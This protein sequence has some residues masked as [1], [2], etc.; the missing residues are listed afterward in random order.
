MNPRTLHLHYRCPTEPG[1]SGGPVF[2][3][4]WTSSPS[5]P[6]E[7]SPMPRLHGVSGV[8]RANEGISIAAIQRAARGTRS[9]SPY[10]S[11]IDC[12]SAEIADCPQFCPAARAGKGRTGADFD[13]WGAFAPVS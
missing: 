2:N 5:I 13:A 4:D 1:S 6:R 8:Y 3:Q 9:A 10:P 12:N 11:A 7:A